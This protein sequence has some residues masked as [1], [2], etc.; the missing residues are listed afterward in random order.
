M[1]Q[2]EV[3][4]RRTS[5]GGAITCTTSKAGNVTIATMHAIIDE[6]THKH[7]KKGD[8]FEIVEIKKAGG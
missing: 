2:C 5:P 1:G 4:V 3:K 6:I 8:K 7:P